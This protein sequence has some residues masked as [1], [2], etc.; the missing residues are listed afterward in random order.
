M[1][2]SKYLAG[3]ALLSA[4]TLVAGACSKKTPTSSAPKAGALGAITVAAGA[5]IKIAVIESISG[6]T[7]S[8]GNDQVRGVQIAVDDKGGKLL[9]HSIQLAGPYDDKCAA[10]GGT[11]SAQKVVADKQIVGVI[12]TSCSG[13]AVPAMGILSPAGYTMISGSNTSPFLTTADAKTPGNAHQ[14]GYFRTA[15]NDTFQGKAAADCAFTTLGVTKAATIN[16]GDPYTVGL[17]GAFADSFKAA[18]GEIVDATAVAKDQTD[19][20]SVLREIA[21]KGPQLIYFPIFEPAADYIVKQAKDIAD[22]KNVALQGADGLIS[23]TYVGSK[24]GKFVIPE[25]HDAPP[26]PKG[27]ARGMYFS[28]PIPPTSGGYT[29]FL[30]KYQTKFGEAPIQAFHAH[31]Y[32]AFNVLAAA[33]EKVAVKQS[34]GSLFIDRQKLR[35]AVG[36]TKDFQGLTGTLTCDQ[37]GDCGAPRI[38]VFQATAAQ[39][40][41]T[42]VKANQVCKP[43]A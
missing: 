19:M 39:A 32:D 30:Q 14:P 13:A 29:T 36:A 35:D 8:L 17:A 16:D 21:S 31:A 15:H 5:P 26:A 40:D 37:F 18:G 43:P 42:A 3:V 2:K 22:L 23:D 41:L 10:D 1:R 34:D 12:G 11:A 20:H 27:T 4:L 7:A 38:A 9:G 25:V 24:S 6:D 33:I 28:G